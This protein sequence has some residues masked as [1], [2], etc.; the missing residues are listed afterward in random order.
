MIKK[1]PSKSVVTPF[2]VPSTT[3]VAPSK[4]IPVSS[5]TVPLTMAAWLK[6]LKLKKS[7]KNVKNDFKYLLYKYIII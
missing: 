5:T 2:V 6:T 1:L 3:I 4:G 7:V